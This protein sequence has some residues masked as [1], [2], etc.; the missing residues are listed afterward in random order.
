MYEPLC[1]FWWPC[2]FLFCCM[3]SAS[4]FWTLPLHCN[5]SGFSGNYIFW[6]RICLNIKITSSKHLMNCHWSLSK[7][8]IEPVKLLN[9]VMSAAVHDK[10]LVQRDRNVCFS[11]IYL[12]WFLTFFENV[13]V[14]RKHKRSYQE[15]D[16]CELCETKMGVVTDT[17][18]IWAFSVPP[19]LKV[20]CC[21]F[22][23]FPWI[24]CTSSWMFTYFSFFLSYSF[25]QVFQSVHKSK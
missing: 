7:K 15:E 13:G 5:N 6:F 9:A 8:P 18:K 24:L 20:W 25:F 14:R 4:W 21:L 11:C 17:A 12:S 1:L 3:R 23:N 10:A 2:N 16:Q 19:A 22:K